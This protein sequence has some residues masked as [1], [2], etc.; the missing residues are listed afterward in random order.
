MTDM[1]AL[2]AYRINEAEETLED[3]R[4]MPA[5]GGSA[6]SVVNR[7]YYSMFYAAIALS[8]AIIMASTG[9]S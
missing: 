5:G 8:V 4:K 3:A 6:R 7:A 1:E 2:F 9:I